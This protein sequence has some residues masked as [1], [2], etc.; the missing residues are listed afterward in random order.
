MKNLT[1]RGCSNRILGF[2]RGDINPMSTGKAILV[3]L[4]VVPFFF[5]SPPLSAQ[6]DSTSKSGQA[7]A[8]MSAKERKKSERKLLNELDSPYRSWLDEDV[9]YIITPQERKAFLQLSTNEERDQFIEE[10]WQRRNPDPESAENTFKEEHYRRIAYADEHFSSGIPGWKT[11][12]GKIYI[13][14]GPPAEVETHPGGGTYMRTPEEG[15][16]VTQAFP[17]EQWRYHYMEGIGEDITLEFVDKTLSGEYHLTMDPCEKDALA[18]MPNGAPTE[19]ELLG[20]SKYYNRNGITTGGTSC[21]SGVDGISPQMNEFQRFERFAKVQAAPPSKFPD[22]VPLVSTRVLRDQL[23]FDY[24]FDFL[25]VTS[26]TDLVP[27]TVEI[28]NRQLSFKSKDG[29]NSASLEVFGRVTTITGRIVQTFEDTIDRDFPESLLRSSMQGQSV[30]QKAVPLRPGLYRLDLV[31]KD[32]NSGN[33]GTVYTRLAVPRYEEGKLEAST[34]VLADQIERVASKQIGLGQFV[35]GD[36]KVRPRVDQ[37]FT[38][39]EQ[40]HLYLQIYN[41][42]VD[43]TTHRSNVGL[44]FIISRLDGPAPKEVFRQKETA[45]KSGH[46]GQQVTLIRFFP[47]AR[48]QPGRYKLTVHITDDVSKQTI[49]PSADFIV[50]EAAAT[51]AKN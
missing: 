3:A 48:F 39:A 36:A 42:V 35:I 18:K 5:S 7:P 13:I 4:I 26:D 41:L 1:H 8:P 6:S 47:L 2:Y 24:R 15:G 17:F 16:G 34:L 28:P 44:E 25:R 11:D 19:A 20:T 32:V 43:E 29:V 30:Y 45:A 46:F 21:G 40:V 23:H 50:K 27:I 14:W 33:V 49:S 38:A 51:A 10:F 31:I 37:S 12:R 22:L 9:V